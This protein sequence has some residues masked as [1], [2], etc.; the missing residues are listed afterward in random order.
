M[1]TRHEEMLYIIIIYI[2]LLISYTHDNAY[3][4]DNRD[5]ILCI[6]VMK[7]SH[8]SISILG[9]FYELAQPTN[10]TAHLL[11]QSRNLHMGNK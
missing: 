1:V 9:T 2:C 5:I 3:H 11:L 8:Y 4:V 7:H 6:A 10:F